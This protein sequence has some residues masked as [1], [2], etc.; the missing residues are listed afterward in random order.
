[1]SAPPGVTPTE[2]RSGRDAVSGSHLPHISRRDV[3]EAIR[4]CVDLGYAVS[5]AEAWNL[6]KRYRTWHEEDVRAFV[7]DEFRAWLERRGDLLVVRGK[8]KHGWA[9]TS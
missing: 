3:R 4:V 2:D 1:M 8:I 9:V 5:G 6:I 7:A